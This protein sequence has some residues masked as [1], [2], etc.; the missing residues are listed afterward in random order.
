LLV[1]GGST[2]VAPILNPP[3]FMDANVKQ[4]HTKIGTS[5]LWAHRHT[6]A[7]VCLALM[8]VFRPAALSP[9][10]WQGGERQSDK[11]VKQIIEDVNQ[12]RDRFEDQLDGKLK[13]STLRGERGEVNVEKYLDDL[14]ESVKRLKDRFN[15]NYAAS[16]EVEAVL[17][18]GSDINTYMKAQPNDL[19]G[20]SEWD[21]MAQ[22]LGRLADAYGATFPLPPGA[23]VRRI[24]DKEAAETAEQVAKAADQL[25]KQVNN[26]ASLTKAAKDA[27]KEDLDTLIEQAKQVKSRAAGSK[28]ATAEVR[29]LVIMAGKIGTFVQQNTLGPGVASAWQAIQTPMTKLQQAYGMR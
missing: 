14:Q 13:S 22:Q 6:W 27:V 29:D 7:G 12:A 21:R 25:K 26:D 10:A 20:Q 8:W 4:P 24:N 18:Q 11:D 16:K 17:R 9:L 15:E 23:A 5:T 2:P 19:K 3:G 28:P 1:Q